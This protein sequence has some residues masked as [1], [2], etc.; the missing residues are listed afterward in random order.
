MAKLWT[1]VSDMAPGSVPPMPRSTADLAT[2][3]VVSLLDVGDGRAARDPGVPRPGGRAPL[4]PHR[5]RLG[6]TQSRVSQSLRSLEHKLGL[7][8]VHRTEPPRH[9]LAGRRAVPRGDQRRLRRAR[10]GASTDARGWARSRGRAAPRARTTRRR[11][12]RACSASWMCSKPPTSAAPCRSSS[13]RSAIGSI[14]CG[15]ARS[16][17]CSRGLPVD[18]ADLVVGPIVDRE[19]RVLAV[20]HD[21]PLA[22]RAAVSHR[23]HRRLRRRLGR[24]ADPQQSATPSSL[25]RRRGRPA[26]PTAPAGDRGH[27]RADRDG[28]AREDRPPDGQLLRLPLRTPERALRPDHRHAGSRDRA[29]LAP[30]QSRARDARVHPHRAR[31]A[32]RSRR[33]AYERYRSG[34]VKDGRRFSR[35]PNPYTPPSDTGGSGQ[36]QRPGVARRESAAGVHQDY[37]ASGRHQRAPR[38]ARDG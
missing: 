10:R 29:R 28:R 19:P 12:G 24:C 37:N 14:R 4:P 27:R 25:A 11:S 13:S 21:H 30:P 18:E 8:L 32:A 22:S 7:E 20:A 35:P 6:L 36:P 17:S 15:A 1:R 9:A 2:E 38:A 5:R 3:R 33:A 23:G 26:D 31:V 16:T 34:S